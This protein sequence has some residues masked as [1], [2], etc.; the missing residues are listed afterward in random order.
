M[1]KLIMTVAEMQDRQAWLDKRGL[2][3]GGSDAGVIVGVNKWKQP[4]QLWL[5]KTG[6]VEQTDLSDN[7][8]VYWGSVLEEAVANRFAEITGKKIRK[9]GLYQSTEYPFM[10]ASPD[11]LVVGEEAGLE[12]KTASGF[13]AKEWEGDSIPDSYYC[14]CQHYLAVTGLKKWYICVLLGGQK[15]IWK[16]VERNED[17]IQALIQAE[18]KFWECVQTETAPDV[19]GS[20][21]KYLEARFPKAEKQTISLPNESKEIIEEYLTLGESIKALEKR[22]DALKAKMLEALGDNEVGLIDAYKVSWSNVKGRESFDK[23]AFAK[24][25]PDMVAKYMKQ[26]K[27]YRKFSVKG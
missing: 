21:I 24:D 26:G 13:A 14:Q 12:V 18:Q 6:Q 3:I 19:D 11:R 17:D 4:Y 25:H 2:G 16:E 8:A 20:A 27:P 10:L 1:A 5:E 22:Q 9:A 7:E 23:E 15:F